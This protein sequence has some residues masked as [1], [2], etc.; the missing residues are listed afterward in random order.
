MKTLSGTAAML[1]N[2]NVAVSSHRL[3]VADEVDK[4]APE[5]VIAQHGKVDLVFNNAAS[6]ST[7][8]SATCL[9]PIGTRLWSES[10][11]C[12]QHDASVLT[13]PKGAT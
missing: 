13:L 2:Y 11:W 5:K 10:A 8:I 6:Q 12:H 7:L 1:K 3:D 4:S 9:N